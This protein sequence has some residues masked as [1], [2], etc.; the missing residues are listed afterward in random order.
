MIDIKLLREN[1]QKFER[2]CLAKQIT[3]DFVKFLKLD[4]KRRD[5]LT[6]I[7]KMKAIQNKSSSE[8]A[9]LQKS[10]RVR[11]IKDMRKLVE[12]IK[13]F[14]KKLE[15]TSEEWNKILYQIPNPPL[16]E[17]KIGKDES[18]NEILRC[19]G[20]KTKFDFPIKDYLELNKRLDLIDLE[21][22]SKVSGTRFGYL[23]NEAVLL[24]FAL[25][26]WTY[27]TLIKEGFTP[28]LSP[29]LV[30]EKAM[31]A[32]GYLARGRDEVYHLPKDE[33]FLVGTS[34]QSIGPMHSD[35]IFTKKKCQNDTLVF[36][37]VFEEKP[38]LTAKIPREF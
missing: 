4:K 32:M 6:K 35:E 19:Q 22:A 15:E 10:E 38:A 3:I 5:L 13:S 37:L 18:D 14:E 24:E 8:I 28:I 26:Q 36:P 34:E 30:R 12:K 11:K 2:A 20:E 16:P 25:I 1:P 9:Q 23:K 29:V 21:R 27:Q 17:V 31:E 7:E 33:L